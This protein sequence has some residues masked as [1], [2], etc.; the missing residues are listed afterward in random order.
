MRSLIQRK[1]VSL[2]RFA[3][4]FQISESQ[5][6][7]WLKR[8]APP[9]HKHWQPLADYFGVS[10]NYIGTGTPEKMEPGVEEQP[11]AYGAPPLLVRLCR[12][13]FEARLAE[14]GDDLSRLGLLLGA[15]SRSL[16]S[17]G[18]STSDS[19]EVAKRAGRQRGFR[20][21][22]AITPDASEDAAPGE[23]TG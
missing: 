3:E 20:A 7:N 10:L 16:I 17:P 12:E 1:G 9:L 22:G 5:L 14:A 4:D 2:V 18:D 6:H 23:K 19:V 15:V 13:Q 11:S 8:P 21:A